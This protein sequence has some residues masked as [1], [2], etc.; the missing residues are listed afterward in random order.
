VTNSLPKQDS[1]FQYPCYAKF[2]KS[3]GRV[4][5]MAACTEVLFREFLNSHPDSQDIRKNLV[6]LGEQFAIDVTDVDS[7]HLGVRVSQ[8][9]ILSIYQQFDEFLFDFRKE[10]PNS[11]E[12]QYDQ[13][14][15]W[16]TR[17]L[18][19]VGCKLSETRK[20][21][22][23]LDIE[24]IQFYRMVRTRFMHSDVSLKKVDELALDLRERL[25]GVPRYESFSAPNQYYDITFDD[26]LLFRRTVVVLAKRLCVISQPSDDAL[27]DMIM[28]PM[29]KDRYGI[30]IRMLRGK[31]LQNRAQKLASILRNL[32]NLNE[33]DRSRIVNKLLSGPLA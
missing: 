29:L 7:N 26:V 14:D 13:R 8:L 18:K 10:H 4:A 33:D 25:T 21:V 17:I 27:V 32:Y 16:L 11:K 31:K 3:V 28:D 1:A 6:K 2:R 30:N 5:A 12:W 22:G 24:I 23:E 15:D 9:N 19:N 20:S